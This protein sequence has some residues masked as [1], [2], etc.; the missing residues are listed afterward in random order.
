MTDHL[1]DINHYRYKNKF[2]HIMQSTCPLIPKFHA[3]FGQPIERV[4]MSA[5][6]E[7]LVTANLK[8]DEGMKL[9]GR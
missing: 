6:R 4:E 8:K 7:H 5:E 2:T 1:V 3:T 9:L